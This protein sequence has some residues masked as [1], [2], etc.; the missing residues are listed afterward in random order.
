MH[1]LMKWHR[2]YNAAKLALKSIPPILSG[3]I[4]WAMALFA[5]LISFIASDWFHLFSVWNAITAVCVLFALS[6]MLNG[7]ELIFN[8]LPGITPLRINNAPGKSRLATR[9]D[10]KKARV[11]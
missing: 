5:L 9:A 3:L 7:A 6:L 1:P 2:R 4:M 11:I 10:L 8:A